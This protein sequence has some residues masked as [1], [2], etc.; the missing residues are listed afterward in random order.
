M[1][2]KPFVDRVIGELENP[3]GVALESPTKEDWKFRWR[4]MMHRCNGAL[5]AVRVSDDYDIS[6]DRL[7]F[8]WLMALEHSCKVPNFE[9][10]SDD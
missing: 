2:D 6:D 10:S 8:L 4:G 7:L 9:E 5:D 1:T 3:W